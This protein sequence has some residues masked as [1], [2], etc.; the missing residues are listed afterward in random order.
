M[1]AP[2]Q[3]HQTPA[4][5]R[6]AGG[7]RV[8]GLAAFRQSIF[9]VEDQ[10]VY[11][12]FILFLLVLLAYADAT[13][14]G[15]LAPEIRAQFHFSNTIF[16]IIVGGAGALSV[17]A[18]LPIGYLGDRF[19]RI[20]LLVL[21]A[22]LMG[23]ATLGSALATNFHWT[24]GAH[25]LIAGG[26]FYAL[27]RCLAGVGE[28]SNGPIQTSLLA[29]YY[30][31]AL[32]P[33]AYGLQR[34]G[35]PLGIIVG[36]LGAGFVGQFGLGLFHLK[37]S[38]RLALVLIAFPAF[39][40][41]FLS[42]FLPEAKRGIQE[43]LEEG[44][45]PSFVV[46]VR[47]LWHIP[48][49]KRLWIAAMVSGAGYIPLLT[50][51][52]LFMFDVYHIGAFRRGL[53]IAGTGILAFAGFIFGGWLAQRMQ[54]HTVRGQVFY[55]GFTI[56][57][58]AVAVLLSALGQRVEISLTFYLLSAFLGAIYYAP[59]TQVT[60]LVSPPRIRSTAFAGAYLFLGLGALVGSALAGDFIDKHGDRAG[61][62]LLAVVLVVG[63]IINASAFTRAFEDAASAAR[64][65][66]EQLPPSVL[67][68][69]GVKRALLKLVA[70]DFAYE[71]N[72]V[73]FGTSLEVREGERVALLG[74]NGAGKSTALKVIAGIL[75]P[76]RGAVFYDG[77][78]ITAHDP[79]EIARRGVILV[80]GGR[81]VFSGLTVRENLK[82]ATWI[83]RKERA[84]SR[85]AVEQAV[86]LFPSLKKRIDQP[87][88]ILSG[89]E[90]QMLGVAQGII[91]RPRVLLIDE[92]TLGLAPLVV[93]ELMRVVSRLSDEGITLV[94]VEQSIN[95]ASLLCERAYFMEKGRVRYEG[96]PSALL[97]HPELVRSVFLGAA[98]G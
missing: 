26:L 2:G 48:T 6:D 84:S 16:G 34:S 95:I 80:P 24:L 74:T 92:L 25:V 57:L 23:V 66:T 50:F 97:E 70:V 40:L 18:A 42:G 56:V 33:R 7:A 88:A 91:C 51:A 22:M 71:G 45:L 47:R 39:L 76:H 93:E 69:T 32:R 62:A 29:D 63:G 52:P 90:R 49:L 1:S 89:G 9:G 60:A 20:D 3:V 36:A 59:L 55:G 94:L 37:P 35:Q 79:E 54:R 46:S 87:A 68:A 53:V 10:R 8:S 96:S 58:A 21:L 82:L 4:M 85:L 38:W 15:T 81:A 77:S 83:Y 41:A 75:T 13:A 86:D 28:I 11:P 73:L 12:V 78:D 44:E 67:E 43:G 19:P 31:P 72:Q 14:V 61:I 17:I 5:L 27:A 98:A 65:L 30:P 64:Q